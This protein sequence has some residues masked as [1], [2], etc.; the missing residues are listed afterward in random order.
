MEDLRLFFQ[1]GWNHIISIDALDHLLFLTALMAVYQLR[2][3]KKVLVLITA[4]TIGHAAT[5]IASINEWFEFNSRW[6]EF[7]IPLTILLT[8][9]NNIFNPFR[10][11]SNQP[12]YRYFMALAFG[13]IH[14]MGFASTLRFMLADNQKIVIPML[15]FNLGIEAGQLLVVLVLLMTSTGVLALTRLG[16]Q[17]WNILISF[18]T[19]TAA[20]FICV[21]RWPI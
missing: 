16:H 5:L 3:W 18:I 9:L 13:L 14:G 1:L 17:Y 12:S 20:L 6:V 10:R 11:S 2:D 15:S 19:G 4:F 7:L 21:L 8:A